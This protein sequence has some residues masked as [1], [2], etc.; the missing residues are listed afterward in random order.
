MKNWLGLK[1]VAVLLG[2]FVIPLVAVAEAPVDAIYL[3]RTKLVSQQIDLLKNRLSQF[4]D[5]L[6]KLERHQDIELASLSVEKV[7]KPLLNQA[8]LDIAVAKSNVDSINIE[9]TESQ[10]TEARLEKDAQESENRLNVVSILGFNSAHLGAVD[11]DHLH[12]KFNY[13]K[14]LLE[15]ESRRV[16]YLQQLQEIAGKTLQLYK[17]KLARIQSLMKSQ[18]MMQ[19]TDRQAKSELAFQQQQAQWLQQ[20]NDLN[21]QLAQLQLS[22]NPNKEVYEKLEADIFYVN[23]SVNFSYLQML[24]VR[25]QNQIQ[26]LQVSIARGGPITLLNKISDQT[27]VLSKQLVRVSDLLN[28]RVAILEK[29][30][31]LYLVTRPNST[32]YLL[33]NQKLGEQYQLALENITTL[34]EK[35][36]AVRTALTRA[37]QQELSLRQG[38]PG[39][40]AKA[41]LDLG[42]GILILPTL[43]FHV[44]KNLASDL[45]HV[46]NA[47]SFGWWGLLFVLEIVWIGI[48]YYANRFSLRAASRLVDHEFGHVNLK[49]LCIR[50]FNRH[51][52]D[53]AIIGNILW[54]F[55]FSGVAIQ[56]ISLI[57]NL[58]LVWL[59][60][61]MIITLAR[62]YLVETVHDRAGTD[63]RLYYRL[64][65]TFVVG[66]IITALAVFVCDLPVSYEVKDLFVRLFL[67]FLL[68][69]S[70]VLLK[71]W[72]VLP[73]LIIPHID[74]RRTYLRKVVWLMGLVIPLV[75]VVNALV[76]LIGFVNLVYIVFWYEGVFLLVLIGYLILRGLLID[77]MEILSNILIRHVANGWL[78]TEAFLKPISKVLRIALFLMAWALLFLFY[79]WDRQSPVVE[80]LNKLIHYRIGEVLNTVITPLSV[81]ELMVIVS[82]LYWAAKWT[83][84]FVYR[85]LA[86]RT[87]DV[88]VRNSVAILSQYTMI[89]VGILIGLRV[90]GV[91]FRALAVLATG[92]VITLAWGLRDVVNNF[93]SGFLL[94]FERPLKVGDVVTINGYEGDVIHIGGRAIT[95]RTWD[96]IDVVVPNSE[97]FTKTFMN[98]TA[99]DNIVRTVINIKIDRQDDP[100]RVQALIYEVLEMSKDVLKDPAPEVFLKELADGL[101]E[102]EVRYYVNLRLIKSR[103]SIRSEVLLALWEMFDKNNIKTSYPP[104]EV[105]FKN[106]AS[107]TPPDA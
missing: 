22:K 29:R 6:K 101:I 45:A 79:G 98:W 18:A 8:L 49:W 71:S 67:L 44:V 53:L 105:H 60:F 11:I 21:K 48:F 23:E 37:L 14:K 75:L 55:Y 31:Q 32:N 65:W 46:L 35:L 20:L 13:Q 80:R 16:E 74:E 39:L 97:V 92:F 42:A 76:G 66:G 68:L 7:N 17:V 56:S 81:I 106:Q 94:L 24:I 2:L 86:S 91:D 38:L 82:L 59:F 62:I 54:L 88:G 15:L 10:Q 26:Q 41:W 43:A 28:K 107:L 36:L 104:R 103:L 3:S 5:E 52:M 58:A 63:V 19:M 25:Y 57:M 78:W 1:L 95:V 85:L 100:L 64:R 69:I 87:H 4:R 61:K 51:V 73:S 12:N 30:Q 72:T 96:H 102:F 77:S 89:V 34:N 27:Q 50:L 93:A 9:L 70:L 99:K 84:E 83:R 33:Q 47:F 40:D 90:L